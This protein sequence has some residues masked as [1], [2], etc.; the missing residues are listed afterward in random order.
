MMTDIHESDHHDTCAMKYTDRIFVSQTFSHSERTLHCYRA[1]RLPLS[2]SR[3]GSGFSWLGIYCSFFPSVPLVDGD[4]P[5]R[6]GAMLMLFLLLPAPALPFLP[7]NPYLPIRFL[8]TYHFCPT[9]PFLS[10]VLYPS[11]PFPA[12]ALNMDSWV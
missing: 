11:F 3:S 2:T 4:W 6:L 9:T 5:G 1:W 7:L 10:L 8:Y 12:M